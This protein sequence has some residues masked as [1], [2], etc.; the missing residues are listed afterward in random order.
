MDLSKT[1]EKTKRSWWRKMGWWWILP[2]V[3][4]I[5]G[6]GAAYYFLVMQ[7]AANTTA[8]RTPTYNTTR[9]TTGSVTISALGTGTL[10]ADPQINLAFSIAGRVG[11]LNVKVGDTVKTGDVLAQLDSTQ[12]LQAN[13]ANNELQIIQDQQ[14]I[15]TLNKNAAVT[16][17]TAF[18]TW[19]A[20][21]KSFTD[22]QTAQLRTA[23]ARCSDAVNTK[24]ALALQNALDKLNTLTKKVPGSDTWIT[25]EAD[26]EQAQANYT[27]C[28]GYTPDEITAAKASEN[29][30]KM[31][32]DQA[33]TNYD[34][35][36]SHNGVDPQIMATDQATL[37]KDQLQ[38]DQAKSDLAGSTI[39]A[40]ADGTII[41]IAANQ[42]EVVDTS[43]YITLA[44]LSHSKVSV[45]INEADMNKMAIG[46]RADIVFDALP[47]QTFT[48]KVTQINP[49]LTT[50]GETTVVTGLIALDQTPM[51]PANN[52]LLPLGLISTVTIVNNEAINVLTVSSDALRSLG[53]GT[54][55]VFVL[56]QGQKLR[57]KPVE[58]GLNDSV[59]VEIK[60][61]LN[62]GDVV[63]TGAAKAAQ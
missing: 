1:S 42:G 14:A 53:D 30:A 5:A 38:L 35:L 9:V 18:Q 33:K 2:I 20:A 49:A 17:A 56:G 6:G 45:Q 24:N 23:Y 62:A 19:T 13:I 7:P 46:N 32:V 36:N 31:T 39:T 43:T 10:V 4:L 55:G 28:A 48:G 3:I 40:T 26:Y 27:Y 37:K 58:I 12:K 11:K 41:A 59:N 52:H 63:S 25:A 21:Q 51:N 54:Y 22:A 8:S 57:L 47:K 16:L 61:G 50:S 34:L 44:D 60:S 15:D 29:I